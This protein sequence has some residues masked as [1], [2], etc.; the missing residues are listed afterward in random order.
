MRSLWLSLG[1][2]SLFG[3]TSIPG[4]DRPLDPDESAAMNAVVYEWYLWGMPPVTPRCND[5]ISK[6]RVVDFEP[7]DAVMSCGYKQAVACFKY[8]RHDGIWPANLGKTRTPTAYIRD[9]LSFDGHVYAMNH[10]AI[11]WM[12][13]CTGAS[14]DGD[15]TH[16]GPW[17]KGWALLNNAFYR[18]KRALENNIGVWDVQVTYRP[19]G[20][21]P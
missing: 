17:F 1:F 21:A 6:W 3:C 20:G 15:S 11:H 4:S 19:D 5:E 13:T 10:E 2:L 16:V 12:A 9:D 7:D 18:T 8:F 14:P